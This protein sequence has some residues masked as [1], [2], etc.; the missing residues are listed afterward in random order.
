[1][2]S[3]IGAS[4]SGFY[5]WMKA[6][7][8]YSSPYDRYLLLRIKIVYEW[9][10]RT[11]G[12]RRITWALKSQGVICYRNQ[13]ARIMKQNG[14]KA[15]TKCKFRITTDSRHNLEVAPNLL[16]R[17]FTVK[18]INRIWIGDITYIWTREGWLYLS[19]VIDLCSRRVVGWSLDKRMSKNLVISSFIKAVK[20][21]RPEA[22]LI[23]HSDRGAQYV[24][25]EFKKALHNIGAVQSM[26]RRGNCWDNAVAESFFKTIKHELVYWKNYQSRYEAELSIF[27]YIEMFYNPRRLHSAINYMSPL[28]FEN[29][30]LP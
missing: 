20:L 3:V 14:I 5:R 10:K 26:S 25:D 15:K 19:T 21:R 29:K 12:S 1:M 11:Y 8:G 7:W 4:K 17:N 22:G 6:Q 16:N 28:S 23:F 30:I 27:E 24:S 18:Q 13:I 9:S 2:C